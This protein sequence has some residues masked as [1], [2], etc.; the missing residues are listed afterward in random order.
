MTQR[1]FTAALIAIGAL[2]LLLLWLANTAPRDDGAR[3]PANGTTLPTRPSASP[4]PPREAA[5]K[6]QSP[7]TATASAEAEETPTAV[8]EAEPLSDGPTIV[9]LAAK[10]ADDYRQRAAFPPWSHPLEDGQDPIL[11]D[12][13]VSPISAAGPNGEAPT[14][15]VFPAQ[16][17]FEMPD[18]ALLLAY[19]T[20]ESG[21]RVAAE[22]IRA[23]VT[24]EL[25]QP[26][27]ELS[28]RDDG[29]D[30][31]NAAGDL[32]YTAVY[33][34]GEKQM[35]ALSQSFLVQVVAVLGDGGERLAATSFLYSN[36]HAQLTG[37]Y[38]DSLVDGNLVI[39]AELAVTTGGRFHIEGTLYDASGDQPLAWAQAASELDEGRHWLPLT[40][41]GTILRAAAIDGPYLLRFVALSTTTAM[42]NAKNRLAESVHLTAPYDAER[43]SDQPYGDP[44][45]LDAADRLEQ[46][47]SGGALQSESQ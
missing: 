4:R 23:T 26:L 41:F 33:R 40:F 47:L 30:G 8:A 24:T 17:G 9:S 39:E 16:R 31:D 7:R 21:E 35:P 36:P 18:P 5:A 14:L 10:A 11:R 12:L 13:E 34:P 43:F 15:V 45:L 46:D 19:L 6:T 28:Y 2:L 22:S 3:A 32:I 25:L 20:D 29:A 44:E 38:R 27:A 42:P 1:Q 37:N